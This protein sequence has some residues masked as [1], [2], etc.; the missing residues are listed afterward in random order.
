MSHILVVDDEEA[1][2]WAL[3]RA[4][5]GEGHT[6][7]VAATAEEAM[8]LCK[9]Q[10]P[11]VVLLDV[12]LPGMDGISAMAQFRKLTKEAPIIIMTAF[13]NLSTAVEAVQGGAFEYLTKPF[14]L[15][16]A[17]ELVHQAL[18]LGRKPPPSPAVDEEFIRDEIVGRTPAMQAIFKRIAL[19]APR[20]DTCVLITGESGTGKELVAR[21]VHRHS[22]PPRQ[23]VFAHPHRFAKPEPGRKRIV[24]TCER[25][26]Y[27]SSGKPPRLAATCRRRYRLSR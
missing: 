1:V 12:R 16:Q 5:T 2:C 20:D 27:G 9:K 6:V 4:F 25:G 18:A 23:A 11:D 15:N 19:V 10:R 22:P 26:V 21:A 24:R 3:R 14:D 17:L 7:E 8:A 13:G